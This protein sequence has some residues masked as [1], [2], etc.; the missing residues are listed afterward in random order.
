[1]YK[2]QRRCYQQ[3]AANITRLCVLFFGAVTYGSHVLLAIADDHFF[4][5]Y[6]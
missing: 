3:Q 4:V 5:N 2:Q 1:M 6:R